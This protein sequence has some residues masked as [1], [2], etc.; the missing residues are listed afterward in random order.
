[1]AHMNADHAAALL[2]YARVHARRPDVTAARMVA[3]DAGG[4]DLVVQR[5]PRLDLERRRAGNGS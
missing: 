1:V 2:G 4:L 5:D 3:I